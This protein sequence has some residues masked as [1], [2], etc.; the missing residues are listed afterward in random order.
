MVERQR[1]WL[2]GALT[3]LLMG[4][5][6]LA[7]ES[8][9]NTGCLPG[10]A[11]D[12]WATGE[13]CNQYVVDLAPFSTSWGTQFGI[14]PIIK[15]SKTSSVAGP[16]GEFFASLTSSQALSRTQRSNVTLSG[17]YDLWTVPGEG[18]NDDQNT[19]PSGSVSL[20][21][22]GNQ[23][24]AA[25]S[26]FATTDFSLSYNAILGA[27]VNYKPEDPSRLYVKRV[28][29]ASSGCDSFVN[30]SQMGLGSVDADGN[31]IFRADDFGVSNNPGSG[32]ACTP[33]VIDLFEDNIFNVAMA[34]RNCSAEN[35]ISNSHPTGTSGTS[36]LVRNDIAGHNTPAIVPAATMGG[37]PLYIGSNFNNQYVRGELYD[38]TP[39][40]DPNAV[41]GDSTHF[42]AG[43]T[44]H[45]G[46]VSWTSGNCA[47][48]GTIPNPPVRGTAALVAR[49]TGDD[50][51]SL[52][53]WGL[54]A[55]GDVTG[56]RSIN[57]PATF[58]TDNAVTF[59]TSDAGTGNSDEFDNYHGTAAFRGGNG[60]VA[61]G[62]DQ[63]G[64]MLIAAQVSHPGDVCAGGTCGTRDWRYDY[65]AVARLDCGTG[66]V[67]WQ[68]AAYTDVPDITVA[69]IT[70]SSTTPPLVDT[71]KAVLDGPG[72][73]VI[74]HLSQLQEITMGTPRGP[75]LSS[76]MIDSVGN[77]WFI[78]I[79]K[80]V[81]PDPI[82]PNFDPID[83]GLFRSVYNPAT[84]EYEL[85]LV[86]TTG[87]IFQGLNSGMDY[88][89]SFISTANSAGGI[90]SGNAWSQN[91]SETAH[92]NGP[93]AGLLPSSPDTLGGLVIAAEIT[94]DRDE[95]MDFAQPC[96]SSTIGDGDADQDYNV[97]LYIGSLTAAP[98]GCP[99]TTLVDCRNTA[100]MDDNG[101]NHATCVSGTCVYTCER[102]GD[103]QPPGGNG[104]V[105]LDDILCILSGFSNFPS[106]P[107]ADIN[108]CGGNGV[109]NLD[110]IL[111]VLSA[112]SGA[113]PCTCTENGT[114]GGGVSPL[115]GSTMP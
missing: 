20:T 114:P 64:R 69:P 85:E 63:A 71:G 23:F 58:T 94:Y 81:E 73:N 55:D 44:N 41:R 46:N 98:T 96:T 68:L 18:I 31:V 38:I 5:A 104:V 24:A 19:A 79:I 47:A 88:Q 4:S 36:W 97:L 106:C 84:F 75:S 100:C 62:A 95:D 77:V 12:P 108:P 67:E 49:D 111:A 112:F 99:C 3:C 9:S 89:I 91:I 7:Q 74:G 92:N 43:V 107:N 13:Q 70:D 26:E 86:L 82:P 17:S 2:G 78:G 90:S 53:V 54:E 40:I 39:P 51:R 25:I 16:M 37:T 56:K 105:N 65:I 83:T 113:N 42:P 57:L 30:V 32:A 27:I 15:S 34:S 109:I 80:Y 6:A 115:C 11:V 66:G 103:V 29:A 14:A 72:G 87:R 28:V 45:R 52:I 21:G 61:L 59:P 33:A 22:T 35:I 102:Y 110:D 76:P 48:L 10:D 93:K 8:V 101:C 1:N 60:Q 50:S